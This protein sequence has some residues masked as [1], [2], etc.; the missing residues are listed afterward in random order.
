MWMQNC[1]CVSTHARYQVTKTLEG[2][3][4]KSRNRSE[5][6]KKGSEAECWHI[7]PSPSSIPP[8]VA[9]PLPDLTKTTV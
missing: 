4:W 1:P 2:R 6:C 8:G 3:P 7:I 9:R 5:A